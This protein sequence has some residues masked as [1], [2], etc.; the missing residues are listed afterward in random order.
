MPKPTT[1]AP[2]R[3]GRYARA[4]SADGPHEAIGLTARL[5]GDLGLPGPDGLEIAERSIVATLM[6]LAVRGNSRAVQEIW[7]RIEGRPG[8][9]PAAPPITIDDATARKIL[10]AALDDD[11]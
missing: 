11:G 9:K 2:L 8:D 10:E 6:E 5:R 3:P 1:H 4:P 7:C